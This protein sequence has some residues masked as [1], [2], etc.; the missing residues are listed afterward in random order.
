LVYYL[1]SV[2]NWIVLSDQPRFNFDQNIARNQNYYWQALATNLR[3][4]NQN[5]RNGN[6]FVVL[7]SELR[8]PVF[9]YIIQKPIKSD[10][11]KNFQIIG[12]GDAGTAWNGFDPYS[13]ENAFNTKTITTGPGGN[14]VVRIDNK[15]DPFVGALGF[16]LRTKLLGYF[17]RWDYAWGIEDGIFQQPM[18]HFSMGLDF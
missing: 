3:G 6:S 16:G 2:D 10:F 4:F 8:I 9:Q 13:D 17:L 14:L 1:G 15:K 18:A 12:F 11:I 5:I 7:N